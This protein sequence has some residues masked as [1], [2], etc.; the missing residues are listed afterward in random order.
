ME[1]T[2]RI[3]QSWTCSHL[4]FNFCRECWKWHVK[5]K[6][7]QSEES[8]QPPKS[9]IIYRFTMSNAC[10]KCFLFASGF[11]FKRKFKET[12]K[13]YIWRLRSFTSQSVHQQKI[14]DDK[15]QSI[16]TWKMMLQN[17]M[18]F[19]IKFERK[20]KEKISGWN[21][22]RFVQQQNILL[23]RIRYL[24]EELIGT[25][26][27]NNDG[28]GKFSCGKR[29]IDVNE[30]RART[31]K[32]QIFDYIEWQWRRRQTSNKIS[33]SA[34][35]AHTLKAIHCTDHLPTNFLHRFKF[36]MSSVLSNFQD[37][38]LQCRFN[39]TFRQWQTSTI[40]AKTICIWMQSHHKLN[41]NHIKWIS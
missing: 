4:A 11:L 10:R 41:I 18:K 5:I 22:F 15:F 25:R 8:E 31:V 12:N 20:R 3:K 34:H 38:I 14:E 19:L 9:F 37:V 30:K 29:K 26:N 39:M 24:F 1:S 17:E 28:K 7:I 13:E 2:K 32:W 27:R 35:L 6:R 33:V 21:L 23:P 16:W 36:Q 40:S